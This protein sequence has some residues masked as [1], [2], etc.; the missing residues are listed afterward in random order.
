MLFESTRSLGVKLCTLWHYGVIARE[1]AQR[2]EARKLES[3]AAFVNN[4]VPSTA[5]PLVQ[6][7]HACAHACM[8]THR[9]RRCMCV[10]VCVRKERKVTCVYV[11]VHVY[12]EGRCVCVC[13]CVCT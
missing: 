11:C 10:C 6:H 13:V 5:I 2:S 9:E 7:L 4:E 8:R 1:H 3:F 12:T